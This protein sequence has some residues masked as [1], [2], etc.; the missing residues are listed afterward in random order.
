[1]PAIAVPL[2]ADKLDAWDV[3]IAAAAFILVALLL[4]RDRA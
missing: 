1:M 2:A 4:I 3:W